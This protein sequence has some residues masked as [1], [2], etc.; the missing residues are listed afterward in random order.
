MWIYVIDVGG[1]KQC[2]KAETVREAMDAALKAY[3]EEAKEAEL[4]D[5]D[6]P[7]ADQWQRTFR[8]CEVIGRLANP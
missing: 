5:E 8:S 6:D 7:P 1:D 2:W 4:Y 3:C